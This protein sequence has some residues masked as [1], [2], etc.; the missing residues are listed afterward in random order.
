MKHYSYH[1]WLVYF[2]H[3][4]SY[5]FNIFLVVFK[6][7]IFHLLLAVDFSP[8]IFFLYFSLFS[9]FSFYLQKYSFIFLMF[10]VDVA[11]NMEH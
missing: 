5:V 2:F 10:F 7:Y 9:L 3:F 8:L 6:K 4:F 1:F 11:E